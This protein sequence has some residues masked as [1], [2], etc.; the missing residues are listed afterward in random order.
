MILHVW[1]KKTFQV[2]FDDDVALHCLFVDRNVLI[3]CSLSGNKPRLFAF[4]DK[5]L[6]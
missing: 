4:H 5:L 6:N 3:H 1:W 2:D